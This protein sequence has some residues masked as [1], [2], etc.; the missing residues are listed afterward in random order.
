[1]EF[2][3]FISDVWCDQVTLFE[4]TLLWKLIFRHSVTVSPPCVA[5]SSCCVIQYCS[6]WMKGTFYCGLLHCEKTV[7]NYLP[8]LFLC[9]Q[10]L[11]ESLAQISTL[12]TSIRG[13][14]VKSCSL[15]YFQF[16]ILV[17][18]FMK[19]GFSLFSLSDLRGILRNWYTL[20]LIWWLQ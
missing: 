16:I 18:L 14:C 19:S 7:S 4:T 10:N 9:P 8:G 3:P 12:T 11:A 6:V 20:D 1:M 17:S 2:L 5:S 13:G 15:V